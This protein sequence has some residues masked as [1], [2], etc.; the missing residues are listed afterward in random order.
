MSNATELLL[1][2][3]FAFAAYANLA[4]GTLDE[5]EQRTALIE[6]GMSETQAQKFSLNYNVVTQFNDTDTS[7]SATV[8]K[9][10][11]GNLTLGIK[12]TGSGLTYDIQVES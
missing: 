5:P 10:A 9:D 7:F 6:A 8:F 2:A 4:N 3:E 1:N 12:G 11:S